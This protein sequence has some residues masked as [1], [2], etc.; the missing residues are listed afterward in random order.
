M[1][2]GTNWSAVAVGF[3]FTVLLHTAIFFIASKVLDAAGVV[4]PI[5]WAQ[6]GILAICFV[7][8]KVWMA[9]VTKK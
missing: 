6:S 2:E 3:G 1:P 7:L 5:S 8:S 4:P 9:S